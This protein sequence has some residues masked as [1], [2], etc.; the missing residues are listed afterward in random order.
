MWEL[1]WEGG[2]AFETAV[3]DFMGIRFLPL[4]DVPLCTINR[5]VRTA[6][7]QD[8]EDAQGGVVLA[9]VGILFMRD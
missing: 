6:R 8:P 2:E 1:L 3:S 4:Y 7:P 5:I 9:R